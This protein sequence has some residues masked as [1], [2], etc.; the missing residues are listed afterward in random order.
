MSF[1][2]PCICEKPS[3]QFNPDTTFFLALY[4]AIIKRVC[5]AQE[6]NY[7]QNNNNESI[8]DGEIGFSPKMLQIPTKMLALFSNANAC[9]LFSKKCRHNLE[10][11]TPEPQNRIPTE[12]TQRVHD[13]TIRD[14]LT[15]N[16][17]LSEVTVH[18]SLPPSCAYP[19]KYA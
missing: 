18:F 14:F 10:R 17:S 11:P 9:L 6:S 3:F 19:Q 13:I 8:N 4:S 2:G 16:A 15:K 7:T 1:I 12:S 5:S